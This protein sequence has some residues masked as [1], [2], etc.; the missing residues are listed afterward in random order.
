MDASD[1]PLTDAEWARARD[2]P[3][4]WIVWYQ[5][6][7]SHD[8]PA[9]MDG[10]FLSAAEAAA[11]ARASN[12]RLGPGSYEIYDVTGPHALAQEPRQRPREFRQLL[13]FLDGC[14]KSR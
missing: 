3:R 9:Y 1:L 10:A 7:F 13:G 11:S 5:D 12:Q 4:F 6:R 8:D 2:Y 14:A